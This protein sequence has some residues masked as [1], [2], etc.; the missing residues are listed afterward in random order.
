M[1][2]IAWACVAV[3]FVLAFVAWLA[4]RSSDRREL[5]DERTRIRR[6]WKEHVQSG[7]SVNEARS[8][9]NRAHPGKI[10]FLETDRLLDQI[11]DELSSWT[12]PA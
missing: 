11:D 6:E 1:D 9:I 2:A 4:F 3:P 7:G 8:R 5:E 12:I 10:A